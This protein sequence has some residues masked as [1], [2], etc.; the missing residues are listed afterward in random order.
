M[1]SSQL[2]NPPLWFPIAVAPIANDDEAPQF[3]VAAVYANVAT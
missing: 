3:G 2:Y 1:K